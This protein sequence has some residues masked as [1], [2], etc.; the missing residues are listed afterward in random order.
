MIFLALSARRPLPWSMA[1]LLFALVTVSGFSL[2]FTWRQ[3]HRLLV[4]LQTLYQSGEDSRPRTPPQD[5]PPD[6][7]AAR[8][9]SRAIHVKE[10]NDSSR[11]PHV[12]IGEPLHRTGYLYY[13][14]VMAGRGNQMVSFVDAIAWAQHLNRTLVLPPIVEDFQ[15]S[16]EGH[17]RPQESKKELVLGNFADY[18]ELQRL[19]ELV[20]VI[21]LA[22]FKHSCPDGIHMR[23]AWPVLEGKKTKHARGPDRGALNKTTW[24]GPQVDL[25][26][27]ERAKDERLEVEKENARVSKH[28]HGIDTLSVS[29]ISGEELLATN[30]HQPSCLGIAGKLSPGSFK[31]SAFL[32]SYSGANPWQGFQ[33]HNQN[34]YNIHRHLD[35]APGILAEGEW[36]IQ[37]T[38]GA[39]PFIAIH[40]RRGDFVK[41]RSR[42]CNE[43]YAM[44]RQHSHLD[45]QVMKFMERIDLGEHALGEEDVK[46]MAVCPSDMQI[47]LVILSLGIQRVFLAVNQE[48]AGSLMGALRR[49]LAAVHE[50]FFVYRYEPRKGSSFDQRVDLQGA[51]EQYVSVRASAF[52]GVSISSWSAFVYQQRAIRYGVGA[53]STMRWMDFAALQAS[54]QSCPPG[55][56]LP[57][58]LQQIAMCNQALGF[59]QPG[60]HE[61]E[62]HAAASS[63]SKE[64][65]HGLCKGLGSSCAFLSA[66]S[67]SH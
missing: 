43:S 11:A 59:L 66:C 55:G 37:N 21:D 65:A 24:S 2:G 51:V 52:V 48:D 62:P 45:K 29:N 53:L 23:I 47:A 8:T 16:Y 26:V 50:G 7:Q 3:S 63:Y 44:V 15:Y 41:G 36:F 18:F 33:M 20:P 6:F 67:N 42:F 64:A 34:F 61:V 4:Q 32:G 13:R 22:Q 54:C 30:R 17:K 56:P 1:L 38:I 31:S 25:K 12:G 28:I 10:D 19:Q 46:Q 57:E 9:A 35:P 39:E 27:D 5:Y 14:P 49:L 40:V 58:S 60:E